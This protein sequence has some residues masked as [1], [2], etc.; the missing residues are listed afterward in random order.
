MNSVK[1]GARV[2][3]IG[4]GIMG[5][6]MASNLIRK[7]YTLTVFNRSKKPIDELASIGASA[8]DSPKEVAVKSDIILDIVTDAPD[9]EQVL[10]GQGGVVEGAHRG[11]IMIDMSTNS[12]AAARSFSS[13]LEERGIEFLDAPVS[14]GD[15]GAK[16]GTLTIMVGGKKKFLTEAFQCFKLLVKRFS[17]WDLPVQAKL[18]SSAIKSLLPCIPSQRANL[19]YLVQPQDWT[20]L[21]CLRS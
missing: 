12:P 21:I 7:G 20:S 5:K 19:S 16:E 2:G 13:K 17:T 15:K 6:P 10:F 8:A 4:L 9:V 3:F 11:T 14:G 1:K 18:Q